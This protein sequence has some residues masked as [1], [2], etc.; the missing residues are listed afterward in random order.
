MNENAGKSPD[1]IENP[2]WQSRPKPGAS[3]GVA[4][5]FALASAAAAMTSSS[6][7]TPKSEPSQAGPEPARDAILPRSLRLAMMA[8]PLGAAAALGAF[9][10][11]L[12][13]GGVTQFWPRVAPISDAQASN[14]ELAALSALK[15]YVEGAARNANNQFATLANRLDRIERTQAEPNVKL[16]RI[17]P[18]I[19]DSTSLLSSGFST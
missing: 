4:E 6:A 9:L 18:L 13:A 3:Q 16:A 1:R 14:V 17:V 2:E 15:T 10:G 19:A 5:D 12:T 7:D 11:S 8:V